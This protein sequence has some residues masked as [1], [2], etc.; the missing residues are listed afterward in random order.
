MTR[1]TCIDLI[2]YC[3]IC[4]DYLSRHPDIRKRLTADNL[5]LAIAFD[6]YGD[7]YGVRTLVLG[8]S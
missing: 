3:L 4:G 6:K 5:Q 1:G 8:R 2:A 7:S